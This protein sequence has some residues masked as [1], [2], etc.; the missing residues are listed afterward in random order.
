MKISAD[1]YSAIWHAVNRTQAVIEFDLQGRI[2]NANP[3]FLKIFGYTLE[4]L[5]NQHHR[6]LCDPAYSS[7]AQYAE[8]W[9]ALINGDFRTGDYRRVKKNGDFV[10]L[11]ATYAPILNADGRPERVIKIAS[12]ITQEKIQATEAAGKIEAISRSQAVIEFDLFGNILTANRN[13]LRTMGYTLPEII[14]QH[15][16]M[17]CDDKFIKTAEYRSFWADLGEGQFKSG[18][19]MRIGKHNAC[20][21]IQA[22]YNPILD[23]EGRPFKVVK[24]A[25]DITHEVQREELIEDRIYSISDTLGGLTRSISSIAESAQKSSE[26]A[27][28]TQQEAQNG[29]EL[30]GLSRAAILAIQKSSRDVKE[31]VATITDLA[32]QTNLLAFNAAIEAARAGEHG[33]GFSVVAD[34][35]RKLAEK[36]ARSAHEIVHLISQTIHQVDEG[37]KLSARVEHV[38]GEIG[39]SVNTTTKSINE[40]RNSTSEQVKATKHVTHLLSELRINNK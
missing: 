3:N 21:W 14:G 39:E 19:F 2:L 33:L 17:F 18:R 12:D 8:H 7:S 34:E 5:A 32:S 35:V 36:S 9:F 37:E 38:F 40:I 25:L 1:G 4:E 26:L 15:H 23:T 6:V 11:H 31:I 22:T 10:W 28:Y 13:F 20:I 24:F 27:S 16:S 30:L 29:N